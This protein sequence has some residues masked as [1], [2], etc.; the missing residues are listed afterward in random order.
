[1]VIDELGVRQA[2]TVA[3]L[4]V[5]QGAA[6]VDTEVVGAQQRGERVDRAGPL[7]GHLIAG[8]GEDPQRGAVSAAA[9]ATELVVCQAA[10]GACD[11]GSVEAVG[12]SALAAHMS[13]DV[14]G[15]GHRVPV[16]GEPLGEDGSIGTGAVDDDQAGP[17]LDA[18]LEPGQG[19][20]EPGRVGRELAVVEQGAGGGVEQGEGVS[21]GVGVHADQQV[22][23]V[24]DEG[25]DDGHTG[26]RPLPGCASVTGAG[27]GGEE[28]SRQDCDGSRLA[29]TSRTGF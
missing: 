6:G 10:S 29:S 11:L 1:V 27:P 18:A 12:L 14:G 24:G 16:G 28:L 8:G 25:C 21:G 23:A 7:A 2:A 15:F 13:G 17:V 4:F 3:N 26:V 20:A 9:G 22:V 5:G 19:A